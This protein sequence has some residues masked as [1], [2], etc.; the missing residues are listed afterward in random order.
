MDPASLI[1]AGGVGGPPRPASE[2]PP[3]E[4]PKIPGD[5]LAA[6]F[7]LVR[8]TI[9]ALRDRPWPGAARY[10]RAVDLNAPRDPAALRRLQAGRRDLA[11]VAATMQTGLRRRL[12]APEDWIEHDLDEGDLDDDCLADL[13]MGDRDV[14]CRERHDAWV[15]QGVGGS[16]LL[17][18]SGSMEPNKV[19]LQQSALAIGDTLDGLRVPFEII[20]FQH[21][22]GIGHSAKVR[23]AD[24]EAIIRQIAIDY[25]TPVCKEGT[26]AGCPD[27]A[28]MAG[29]GYTRCQ[30]SR[31]DVVKGFGSRWPERATSVFGLHPCSDNDD[32]AAIQFVARR[33]LAHPLRAR[34][35]LVLSDGLPSTWMGGSIDMPWMLQETLKALESSG[36]RCGAIGINCDHVR[37][38]YP[39]YRIVKDI[40]ELAEAAISLLGEM[41]R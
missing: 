17:D 34:F 9:R 38:L 1:R 21:L 27:R 29:Q 6:L 20:G 16:V 40:K 41:L 36:V 25:Q 10:D 12:R 24:V 14:F 15:L 28:K 32:A 13:V 3:D 39:K 33:L 22:Y 26:W 5:P 23:R 2:D 35:L 11:Q 18:L 19:L 4:S 8:G 37:H 7:G 31:Y 30:P